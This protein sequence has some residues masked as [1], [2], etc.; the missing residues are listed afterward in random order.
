MSNNVLISNDI[1]ATAEDIISTSGPI[2]IVGDIGTGKDTL[3]FYLHEKILQRSANRFF[4]VDCSY[5]K[6]E[7]ERGLLGYIDSYRGEFDDGR[8]K[9]GFLE[10]AV[11]G[12]VY[13]DRLHLANKGNIDFL[14]DILKGKPYKPVG[15]KIASREVGNVYFM[16]SCEPHPYEGETGYLS[17]FLRI[18]FV[19]ELS[20]CQNLRIFQM[21]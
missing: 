13:L 8:Y 18:Y 7:L 15:E 16:A 3:A 12:T 6:V 14:G 20:Y 9:P 4:K 2:L 21:T 19:E 11:E 5:S 1:I 10:Q 17:P